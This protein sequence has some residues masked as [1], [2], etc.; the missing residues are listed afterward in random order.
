MPELFFGRIGVASYSV[1]LWHIPWRVAFGQ[2]SR[3]WMT[4]TAGD[5][6]IEPSNL[7]EV[8]EPL[9]LS[10]TSPHA[11]EYEPA[12]DADKSENHQSGR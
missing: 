4:P 5:I 1:Y 3:A 2:G 10:P 12:G 7:M 8:K 11:V 6:V 9:C